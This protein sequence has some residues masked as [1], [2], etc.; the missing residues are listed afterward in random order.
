MRQ[1]NKTTDQGV[2]RATHQLIL[3]LDQVVDACRE[4]ERARNLLFR[5]VDRLDRFRIVGGEEGRDEAAAR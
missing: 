1:L 3:A 5:E 4:A 2:R